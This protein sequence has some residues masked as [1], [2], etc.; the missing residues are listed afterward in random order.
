MVIEPLIHVETTRIEEQTVIVA[1]GEIDL[2]SAG[3]LQTAI[4]ELSGQVVTVDLRG[5][6]FID[7]TGLA[8]LI[9]EHDRLGKSGGELKLVVQ[10]K[11]PVVRLF[12]LTGVAQSFQLSNSL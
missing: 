9:K 4:A 3:K 5:V 6:E 7:S 12:E 11:G 8:M 2:A 1:T 10:E